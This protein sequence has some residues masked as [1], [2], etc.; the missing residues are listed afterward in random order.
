[1]AEAQARFAAATPAAAPLPEKPSEQ[2]MIQNAVF[3][4]TNLKIRAE[5]PPILQRWSRFV[6][7]RVLLNKGE[8]EAAAR[9]FTRDGKV[10]PTYAAVDF[11][12]ALAPRLPAAE[13]PDPRPWRENL[14]KALVSSGKED[15]DS[16]FVGSPEA[17][18][19]Q[20]VPGGHR[21]GGLMVWID[22]FADDQAPGAP[23]LTVR[24]RGVSS[25]VAIVQEDAPLRAAELAGQAGKDSILIH[26]LKNI[27][28]TEIRTVYGTPAGADPSGYE[29]DIDV[30]FLDARSLPAARAAERWRL[31]DAAAVRA[32]LT[33]RYRP[34]QA[35]A[36]GAHP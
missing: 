33:A 12:E 25:T 36:A 5:I 21:L 17:E 19:A 15:L 2:Q 1:M 22:G 31:I 10:P 3:E 29:S 20:R 23:Y 11:F 30:E 7:A 9:R 13:R 16:M 32:E 35:S 26:R 8:V 18:T 14:H 6:E 34:V 4:Q 27:E 24:Y 28:H